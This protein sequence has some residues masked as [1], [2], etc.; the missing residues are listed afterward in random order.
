MRLKD[1]TTEFFINNVFLNQFM[2]RMVL[3]E[4]FLT[5]TSVRALNTTW[6]YRKYKVKN[7]NV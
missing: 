2:R 5:Y 4:P 3:P 6:L 7:E 1:I